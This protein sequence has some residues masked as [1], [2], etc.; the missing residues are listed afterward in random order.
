VSQR[1]YADPAALRRAIT[2]R[3][4]SLAR[5]RPQAN[6]ADLQRQFAYDRLLT[7]LFLAE[8]E[9]WI[10]KG[11]TA[12]LARLHGSARHTIDVDLFHPDA[13]LEEADA[14]LREA[15]AT[16]LGDFFRF[17][18]APGRRV[19]EGRETLRIPVTVY[20]GATQFAGFHIDLVTDI[21]MTAQP[22]ETQPL[23]RLALP[24]IPAAN[25]RVYPIVDHIAD[26]VC[27]LLEVHP[28]AVGPAQ[29]STRY[30]DL[31]DLALIAHTQ[32]MAASELRRALVSEAR[33]RGIEL[34]AAQPTPE[35]PGW[36]AG[37]ARVAR[38][39]PGLPE[40]DLD[41][42]LTIVRRLI[43]PVLA[44]SATGTWDPDRLIWQG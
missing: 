24:G 25:Y 35:A 11:A 23:V 18:L 3:L 38:D 8:P 37:Y 9:G 1:R 43:D 13:R 16:D 14:A 44:G 32:R 7:R 4:R 6:L 26:K 36:R 27:A 12:L 33:R 40:K 34:P 41:G 21:A 15:A 42:A 29:P 30:R 2:D 19:A 22:D 39:V 20:L 10:L 17:L 5:E 31:A 28:R